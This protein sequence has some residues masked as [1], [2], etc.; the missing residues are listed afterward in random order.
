MNLYNDN[1]DN[2]T[3]EENMVKCPNCGYEW[4]EESDAICYDCQDEVVC[5]LCSEFCLDCDRLFAEHKLDED[6]FCFDCN[7]ERMR[8]CL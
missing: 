4:D 5:E 1:F 6:Q 3:I 7:M 8:S 2:K